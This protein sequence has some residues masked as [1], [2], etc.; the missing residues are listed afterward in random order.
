MNLSL[1]FEEVKVENLEGEIEVFKTSKRGE[2]LETKI[3]R[4]HYKLNS[5]T[6]DLFWQSCQKIEKKYRYFNRNIFERIFFRV[7]IENLMSFLSKETE[8]YSWVL[9][10]KCFF[11]SVKDSQLLN[12]KIVF[13]WDSNDFMFGNFNSATIIKNGEFQ[14]IIQNSPL[15][16]IKIS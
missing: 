1:F 5:E 8:N 16:M 12:G 11:Q 14:Q 10:P 15:K 7:D 4:H 3:E 6:S 2:K 9:S 13:E